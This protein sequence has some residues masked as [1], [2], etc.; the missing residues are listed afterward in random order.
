MQTGDLGVL[1]NSGGSGDGETCKELEMY[2][3]EI[4]LYPLAHELDFSSRQKNPAAR[5]LIWVTQ[6]FSF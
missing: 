4:A 1:N 2:L 6:E 5:F 3:E